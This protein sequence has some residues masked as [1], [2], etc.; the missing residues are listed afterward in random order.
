MKFLSILFLGISL[1]FAQTS[2]SSWDLATDGD[3]AEVK[4]VEE[5]IFRL[6]FSF[7]VKLMMDDEVVFK[8]R[9]YN[10]ILNQEIESDDFHYAVA[11]SAEYGLDRFL[12]PGLSI[13][14]KVDYFYT[15]ISDIT[16]QVQG[17]YGR[18]FEYQGGL[19]WIDAI[20]IVPTVDIR[21][22]TCLDYLFKTDL[23][24]FFE[25]HVYGG[26]R[27]NIN[28]YSD[29]D[30][31]VSGDTFNIGYEIGTK[32]EFFLSRNISLQGVLAYNTNT[33]DLTI[34]QKG[35]SEDLFSGELKLNGILCMLE[36]SCYF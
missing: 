21:V 2:T 24:A 23:P 15:D 28:L 3:L 11:L 32:I 34:R 13:G 10:G 36:L 7:G 4:K 8:N 30:L 35:L 31:T 1:L 18:L 14:V 17:D 25:I 20:G 12:L 16:V 22:F 19:V 27:A 26:L 33:A 6:G 9:Y 5:D 29:E